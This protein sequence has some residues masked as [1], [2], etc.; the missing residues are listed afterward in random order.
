[1]KEALKRRIAAIGT[2]ALVAVG[3][4]T[5]MTPTIERQQAIL[6]AEQEII[7]GDKKSFI[8]PKKFV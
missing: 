5:P 4:S 7:R 3:T 1:M 2:T 8:P 6:P